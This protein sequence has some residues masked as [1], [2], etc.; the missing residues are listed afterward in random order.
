[1]ELSYKPFKKNYD[2]DNFVELH[3]L[4]KNN[5][6][7]SNPE[8]VFLGDSITYCFDKTIFKEEY[9][10]YSA[11]NYG[12]CGDKTQHVLWRLKNGLLDNINPKVL[13]LLIGVNNYGYNPSD[14]AL[15]IKKIIKVIQRKIVNI[16]ILLCGIFPFGKLQNTIE[17]IYVKNVNNII[18]NFNKK[19]IHYIDFGDKFLNDDGSLDHEIMPDYLHLSD[20]GYIIFANSIRDKLVELIN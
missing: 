19:N 14:T 9:S 1:M 16:K 2:T 5:N 8:L 7:I 10:K 11:L 6:L 18:K 17:R 13:V 15:G 12:I 4:Y 3:N 20:K